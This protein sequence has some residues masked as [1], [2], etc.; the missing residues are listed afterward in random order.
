M[1]PPFGQMRLVLLE[2]ELLV[3]GSIRVDL[4]GKAGRAPEAHLL[5]LTLNDGLSLTLNEWS[6]ENGVGTY[7]S[8]RPRSG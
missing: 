6:A 8:G 7:Q 4:W 5:T 3:T 1:A 2:I